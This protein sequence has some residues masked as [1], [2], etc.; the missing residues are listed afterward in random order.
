MDPWI[1]CG[2]SDSSSCILQLLAISQINPL[3]PEKSELTG[4]VKANPMQCAPM[5]VLDTA[6]SEVVCRTAECNYLHANVRE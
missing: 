5:L 1:R 6:Q 4:N 3:E 2:P